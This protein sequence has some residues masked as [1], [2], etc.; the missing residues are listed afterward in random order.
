M[1]TTDQ[2][3]TRRPP[4]TPRSA[5]SLFARGSGLLALGLAWLVLGGT[6]LTQAVTAV[7]VAT[8][9]N[10]VGPRFTSCGFP[11]FC[12]TTGAEQIPIPLGAYPGAVRVLAA[13]PSAILAVTALV[14]LA[15]TTVVLLG[16]ARAQP[17]SR[18]VTRA[19]WIGAATLVIGGGLAVALDRAAFGALL[20][21]ATTYLNAATTDEASITA[22]YTP[23]LP[24]AAVLAGMMVAALASAFARGAALQE[25]VDGLV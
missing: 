12:A 20:D 22:G 10:L 5:A 17:F 19:L 1:T 21:A 8:A 13:T 18:R 2:P 7:Q 16:V 6:A 15:A 23:A 4:A 25:D 9:T 14:T 24:A 3:G 11:Q